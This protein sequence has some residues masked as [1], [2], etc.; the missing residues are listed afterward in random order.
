MV[1]KTNPD[2]LFYPEG[3]II[4]SHRVASFEDEDEELVATVNAWVEEGMSVLEPI[5]KSAKKNRKY[6][7]GDQLDDKHFKKG[8]TKVVVN[9]VWQSME[10]MVP[11]AAANI[12]A[13]IITLPEVEDKGEQIDLRLYARQMEEVSLAIAQ[14]NRVDFIFKEVLR[15][16]EIYK[17]GVIYFEYCEEE[18]VIKACAKK[19][20][21]FILPVSMDEDWVIER[22]LKT[23]KEVKTDMGD[24]YEKNIDGVV[25]GMPT[26]FSCKDSDLLSYFKVYTPTFTFC[27]FKTTIWGKRKNVNWNESGENHW[28][29]A[30]IPFI[31]TDMWTLLEGPYAKTTNLEQI[32][33]LQDAV[34]ARKIQI[35]E[36]AR[37][38][39]GTLVAYKGAGAMASDAAELEKKRGVPNSVAFL[40]GPAGSIGEF[41][42]KELQPFV[43]NDM[44]HSIAEIDNVFGVHANLRGE[45]TPGEESGRGRQ[46]LIGGDETRIGELGGMIDR[47]AQELYNAFA[48]LIKVH[49][50]KDHWSSFVGNDGA[51][52]QIKINKSLIKQGLKITVRTGSSIR[53]DEVAL[54]TQALELWRLGALDPVSLFERLNFPN[55]SQIAERLM[56]FKTDPQGYFPEVKKEY[57]LATQSDHHQ[58]VLN[59][60]TQATIE[61]RSL[62]QGQNVAPYKDAMVQHLWAHMEVMQNPEFLNLG[63]EVIKA[64]KTHVLAEVEIAKNNLNMY[65]EEQEKQQLEILSRLTGPDERS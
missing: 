37:H 36:N 32:V 55:P 50:K 34:N 59:A 60:V 33:P 51:S 11:V 18:K 54:A 25:G 63:P 57:A 46:L 31:F 48:Q 10:T 1:N 44:A 27:K 17:L 7:L 41:R 52:K 43:F 20:S 21:N 49:F 38:A 30:K 2:D 22:C 29:R 58:R 62:A 8:T 40:E 47:M 14:E 4:S 53:K 65:R 35:N 9:K 45:K 19:P 26:N 6:Y 39:N 61:N 28:S 24:E 15:L 64:F 56:R 16:H 13:P 5:L 23:W 3:T 42:G 12:P